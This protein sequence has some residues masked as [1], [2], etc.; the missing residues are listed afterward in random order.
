VDDLGSDFVSTRAPAGVRPIS[1]APKIA[2]AR[3]PAAVPRLTATRLQAP[4]VVMR[5]A[6]SVLGLFGSLFT[7]NQ[8]LSQFGF[9]ARAPEEGTVEAKGFKAKAGKVLSWLPTQMARPTSDIIP[10]S[11][12]DG[13]G[14]VFG[15]VQKVFGDLIGAPARAENRAADIKNQLA[16]I[17]S[18][19]TLPSAIN[20]HLVSAR[21][22][23][24][25]N[26]AEDFHT[27]YGAAQEALEAQKKQGPGFWKSLTSGEIGEWNNRRKE[28]SQLRSEFHKATMPLTES[29]MADAKAE[30]WKNPIKGMQ[31]RIAKQSLAQT[32]YDTLR[33]GGIAMSYYGQV[34]DT[35]SGLASLKQ[36]HADLLGGNAK[37]VGIFTLWRT[38]RDS[39][40]PKI[41]KEAIWHYGKSTLAKWGFLTAGTVVQQKIYTEVAKRSG[42]NQFYAMAGSQLAMSAF[43]KAE[44]LATASHDWMPLY[45]DLSNMQAGGMALYAGRDPNL[46]SEATTQPNL[47]KL[48]VSVCPKFDTQTGVYGKEVTLVARYFEAHQTPISEVMT[49][50]AGG[51]AAVTKLAATAHEE[52]VMQPKLAAEKSASQAPAGDR[53]TVGTSLFAKQKERQIIGKHTKAVVQA[54]ALQHTK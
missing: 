7:A 31:S 52:L 25:G 1:A 28:N 15:S 30:F 3:K 9:G 18:G 29:A 22:A 2:P 11:V 34:R 8:M 35:R 23:L 39:K 46:P 16:N 13:I 49:I 26:K 21:N 5:G 51:E 19:T 10:T 17:G 50:L 42:G 53:N 20:E 48:I 6:G 24:V 33:Y 12:T 27:A 41:L 38:Y 4:N 43:S 40:T 47:A 45:E 44:E 54:P 32:A 37:D 14:G 36:L